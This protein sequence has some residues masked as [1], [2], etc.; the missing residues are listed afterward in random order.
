MRLGSLTRPELIFPE[1][2]STDRSR[3][4]KTL[5]DSVAER[6]MVRDADELY[7]KLLE[8]EQLGSTGIGSGVAIP[9]CKLKGLDHGVVAVGLVRGG[10]DFGAVDGRPVRLLFLVVSPVNAPAE[11]LQVLAAISR[12][13][14]TDQHADRI[15]A[16]RDPGEIYDFLRREVG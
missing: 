10:I 3:I 11:H 4:L 8:R 16:L 12:W 6:G 5:A 9:H 1:L 2:V 7:Q 14:K 15:L 13:I